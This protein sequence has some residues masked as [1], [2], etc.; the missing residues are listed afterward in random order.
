MPTL[1]EEEEER[2]GGG[3]KRSNEVKSGRGSERK[4]VGGGFEG[5]EREGEENEEEEREEGEERNY[6]EEQKADEEETESQYPISST[7]AS[8]TPDSLLVKTDSF[9][10]YLRAAAVPGGAAGESDG[11]S[12]SSI[13]SLPEGLFQG[14]IR[15]KDGSSIAVVFQVYTCVLQCHNIT[16]NGNFIKGNV[17][18]VLY[19]VTFLNLAL[20]Y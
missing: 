11:I 18:V 3:E 2:E 13:V 19:L 1:L 16:K 4:E 8:K 14:F 17:A 5:E 10:E 20:M 6:E 15:H 12:V 7:P 9:S